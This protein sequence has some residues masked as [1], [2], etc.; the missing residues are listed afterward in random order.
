MIAC[1]N[2]LVFCRCALRKE[3]RNWSQPCFCCSNSIAEHNR[4]YHPGLSKTKVR[5][6]VIY[7]E[8]PLAVT[9]GDHTTYWFQAGDSEAPEVVVL[10][11]A[12]QYLKTTRVDD[13]VASL[14]LT[15]RRVVV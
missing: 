5:E 12:V 11:P 15:R 10:P 1:P 8:V 9:P 3:E 2:C 6:M 7:T 13:P 14:D 4:V